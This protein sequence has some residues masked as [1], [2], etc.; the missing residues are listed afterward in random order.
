MT[1]E[2]AEEKDIPEI[3]EI[4]NQAKQWFRDN[5]IDQWQNNYPLAEDILQDI[6]KDGSYVIREENKII[7]TCFIKQIVEPT[8]AVIEDGKWLNEDPYI[9]IH[10]TAIDPSCKGKGYAS[11][12]I[13]KAEEIASRD[14]IMNLRAD[15]HQDNHS[16]RRLLEKNGFQRCGIIH[17]RDGSP[18]EAYQK[19]LV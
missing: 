6:Q 2:K 9:V 11:L 3:M 16:M 8:Y 1:V 14:G 19:V 5:G 17:I 4:I 10:R 13:K 7:G 12:F 15:T 18:R